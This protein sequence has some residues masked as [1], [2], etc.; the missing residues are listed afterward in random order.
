VKRVLLLFPTQWD[1]RQLE[2]CRAEWQGEFE[3]VLGHPSEQELGDEFDAPAYAERCAAE[4]RGRIDGVFAS[5]DYPGAAVAALVAQR[6]G[7]PGAPPRAVLRAAHKYY[8]RCTQREVVPESTPRFAWIDP[9]AAPPRELS[10]G[11]P[12]FVK[13][14]KGLFSRWARRVDD[15]D[16]LARL[17]ASPALGEFL[18]RWSAT[19]E[20]LLAPHP[21]FALGARAMIAEELLRGALVTVEGFRQG[22]RLEFL[23]VVDSSVDPASGSFTRFD[24][25][26]RLARGVQE[27]MYEIARRLIPALGLDASF[28]N[29]E[30]FWDADSDRI[31]IVEVNPRMV[32]QFADLYARA[33]GG[34]SYPDAMRL[35]TG[36]A[37]RKRPDRP[38]GCA[39]SVPLRTFEPVRV[40]K[41]PP[42]ERLRALER[43]FPGAP[44]LWSECEPGHV[45]SDFESE[46]GAS[47]RYAIVNLGADDRAQL[48]ARL[49]ELEA[50]LGYELEP[51]R[52]D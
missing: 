47:L 20:R 50:A 25:P 19:F 1:L 14:V 41:A 38:S 49:A 21:E 31:A 28:F 17:L 45:L 35:A 11:F 16:S 34:S 27:R 44:L 42:P 9:A 40:R 52:S 24:F 43:E 30:M 12:C 36:T 4:H 6:L 15:P 5:C 33:L 23:G 29:V 22:A 51:L 32:G 7:L 39:A 3:L 10:T 46:D 48:D 8:A 13:P 2:S 18:A 37:P 26:S